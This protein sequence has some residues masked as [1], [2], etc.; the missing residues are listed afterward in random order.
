MIALKFMFICTIIHLTMIQIFL[1]NWHSI[2]F[3]IISIKCGSSAIYSFLFWWYFLFFNVFLRFRYLLM[4]ITHF[5]IIHIFFWSW[6]SSS[7]I[8]FS[9]LILIQLYHSLPKI[10]W[11]I[12]LS[13]FSITLWFVGHKLYLI[14]IKRFRCLR[15]WLHLSR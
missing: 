2:C 15:I 10:L 8:C 12:R 1:T 14:T 7:I 3:H 6:T 13:S 5:S 4:Q 11:T 9:A